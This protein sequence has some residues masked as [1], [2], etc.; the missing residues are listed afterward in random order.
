[1][2][3]RGRLRGAAWFAAART[4]PL[5]AHW[6]RERGTPVDRW[7]IER[8]LASHASDIHGHVLE[9]MDDRYT[10]QFGAAVEASEV[11]DVDPN[12]PEATL[13]ADLAEPDGFPRE[14]Y[15]CFV[16][17][18]TLQFVYDLQAAVQSV[19]RSLRRGG[20][21]L[22]TVPVVSRLDRP[23][24]NR[25]EFWRVTPGGC[26]RLFAERFGADQV[27]IATYGN[28]LTCVAFLLGL[29]ADDLDERELAAEHPLFPLLVAVRAEKL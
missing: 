3:L 11:L 4:D 2:T 27:E 5:S 22:A 15:D 19:H 21:C 9:V 6:G 1:M 25:G 28:T 18:Q 24:N 16:L 23:E 12:N 14:R 29:P 7:F 20:V 26:E 10:K 13:V 8:F 17:T